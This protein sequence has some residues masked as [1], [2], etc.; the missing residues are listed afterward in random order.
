MPGAYAPSADQGGPAVNYVDFTLIRIADPTT[1][2]SL[3][4]EAALEQMA[5]AAYGEDAA[6]L[7]GPYQPIFR[8][9]MIGLSIPSRSTIEGCW[10]AGTMHNEGRFIIAGLGHGSSARI[11]ALWRGGIIARM[12]QA[13]GKITE[14]ISEWPDPSGIDAEII[15]ALGAL[16][17]N[18]T[19]LETE[20]RDRF[21]ARIRAAL[22]Q[23]DAFTEA[24]FDDWLQRS[25]AVSV[26]DLMTHFRGV[27]STGTLRIRYSDPAAV[28]PSPRELP[29]TAALLLRD[30]PISL[31]EVVSQSKIVVEQLRE[32]G[33][34]RA[35]DADTSA[36]API[37]V[38]WVVPVTMFDDDDWP[39]GTSGTNAEKRL[40]RRR[41]AATWLGP[42][43][44]VFAPTPKHP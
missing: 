27:I 35:R 13:S 39:G 29:I 18:P 20:R 33:M 10:N 40:L 21:L 25:G 31:V 17:T 34:E 12:T 42:Q 19:T 7:S 26:S 36:R 16:P 5:A 9:V 38:V 43:G 14:E 4:D 2:A 15:A 37:L 23:P 8:E 30:Q 28:P 41:A 24:I 32:A 11:D 1:R 22:H 44:I 3:F 6:T